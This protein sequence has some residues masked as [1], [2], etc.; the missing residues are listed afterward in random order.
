MENQDVDVCI[1]GATSAGV[2]AAVQ[3]R[4]LGKSVILLEA[5]QHIGGLTSGGLGETDIGNK[6]AIGGFARE[7]YNRVWESYRE[8]YGPNSQQVSACHEGFRFE[9]SVASRVFGAMLDEAGAAVTPGEPLLR[10]EMQ[11][12]SISRIVA[13]SGRSVRARVY[14]D[15]T[16][17][18]DLMAA[19]GVSFTVGREANSIYGETLNGIH[20]GH[21][22]HNF[23]CPI[24]PYRREGDPQSALL[25]GVWDEP[26]GQQGEGDRRV[27]AYCFRMCMTDDPA[28]RVPFPKPDGYDPERYTLLA[29]YIHAGVW[30]VLHLSTPMPN[31]K[32][33]TNNCGAFSMDNIGR[34][35]G[36]PEGNAAERAAI[37]ADH[38]CYQQ[39]LMW[40]LCHDPRVPTAIREEVS[41]WGLPADEYPDSGHWSPQLYVREARRMVS[42]YVM[43]E[44]NCLG[45]EVVEDAV[46]LAA[47]T[48]DSH[49]C[50][51]LVVE[52]RALNEGNVEQPGFPPYPVAYRSLVPKASE[53]G[54]LLV[55]I[56]LSASHIAY[57]SIRMEP[58]FLLLGQVTAMAAALAVEQ[59]CV[60]QNIRIP[61]LQ[62]LLTAAGARLSWPPTGAA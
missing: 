37:F 5:G 10:A 57:G 19:A 22:N 53:C 36:W 15:A 62:A 58:V 27:Q 1:Y 55:P 13:A 16:Y 51:R 45:R 38:V 50:R 52:G 41:Q 25:P 6:G 61:A 12:R 26:A 2:A 31:R 47:Y 56:C 4:R 14:I 30:D 21:P 32:T 48:M 24:D 17:E 49:N 8:T 54:N 23:T 9:P 11:G 34:N 18:G 28:N 44:H 42:D 29:R 39:G 43:T 60:A 7:F 33:D 40:F 20:F 35:D 59:Q 46:G 3:L